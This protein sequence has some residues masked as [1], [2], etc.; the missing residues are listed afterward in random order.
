MPSRNG[1]VSLSVLAMVLVG[2]FSGVL[3]GLI[4]ASVLTSQG[5]LAIVAAIVAVLLALAVGRAILG[6]HAPLALGS[7]VVLW[8]VIIASVI[9]ALAGHELSVDLRS[10]PASPLIGAMSGLLASLLIASFAITIFLLK[11]RQPG[12]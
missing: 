5:L 6:P 8:N 10:P 3:V 2:A 12:D 1:L 7:V 9:G 11:D 4:L